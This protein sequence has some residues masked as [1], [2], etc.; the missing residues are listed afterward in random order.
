MLIKLD[1]QPNAKKPG[2]KVY[3]LNDQK[4]SARRSQ[5]VYNHSPNGFEHGYEGSGPAQ[6]ALAICLE[7]FGRNKVFSIYQDFKREHIATLDPN[8]ETFTVTLDV[9][10]YA[11]LAKQ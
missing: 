3:R 7:L 6:L 11:E 9:S 5:Q 2:Q 1:C 4:L 10:K 8:A